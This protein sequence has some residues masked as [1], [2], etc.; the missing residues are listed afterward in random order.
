MLVGRADL[1][2]GHIDGQ[3]AALEKLR[4]FAQEHGH[5]A[6]AM[7]VYV[8]TDVVPHKE[9]VGLEAL[10]ILRLRIGRRLLGMDVANFHI[11]QFIVAA[12]HRFD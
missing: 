11:S 1:Q 12:Y 6:R 7:L 9:V 2:E 4:N 10:G 3:N 8:L 5:V